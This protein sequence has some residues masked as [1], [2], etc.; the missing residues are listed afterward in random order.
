[1]AYTWTSKVM[2]TFFLSF[3]Q[4]FWY[5]AHNCFFI[6][7]FKHPDL[8]CDHKTEQCLGIPTIAQ[9]SFLLKQHFYWWTWNCRMHWIHLNG[10]GSLNKSSIFHV[11][12]IIA[13]SSKIIAF[14]SKCITQVHWSA[15]IVSIV[16]WVLFHWLANDKEWAFSSNLPNW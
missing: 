8:F 3:P 13:R 9:T 1:M 15:C 4:Y 5:M 14:V 16:H 10:F 6:L 2:L 11:L 7:D 12:R